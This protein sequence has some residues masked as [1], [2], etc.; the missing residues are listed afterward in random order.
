[1]PAAVGEERENTPG[2]DLYPK[3]DPKTSTQTN[4]NESNRK[5]KQSLLTELTTQVISPSQNSSKRP[6]SSFHREQLREVR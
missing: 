3:P 4:K 5:Q 1:M 6:F 2:P